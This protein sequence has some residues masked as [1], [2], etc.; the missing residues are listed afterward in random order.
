MFTEKLPDT[1]AACANGTPSAVS[2]ASNQ[3]LSSTDATTRTP[4]AI[5]SP[6]NGVAE[7]TAV[8]NIP[9]AASV[10]AVSVA[11][12]ACVRVI[13]L[14]SSRDR[15]E[16][17]S[18]ALGA[19]VRV[20]M[21]RARTPDRCRTHTG[22]AHPATSR[23]TAPHPKRVRSTGKR[24]DRGGS[25]G[26]GEQPVRHQRPDLR[27]RSRIDH[28]AGVAVI[29]RETGAAPGDPKGGVRT[30]QMGEETAAALRRVGPIARAHQTERG[31][32]DS[33]Q[34]RQEAARATGAGHPRAGVGECG[35][36]FVVAAETQP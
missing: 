2:P 16:K 13:G 33:G 20:S 3:W 7:Q 28:Q 15:T 19:P 1:L 11:G 30:G 32:A 18:D 25:G 4:P 34:A 29:A 27:A 22:R 31:D 24:E 14:Q 9:V 6:G 23:A 8:P 17:L 35:G 21:R 5:T 12:N 36:R 26:A 10:S